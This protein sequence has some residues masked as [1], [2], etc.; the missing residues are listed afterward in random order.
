MPTTISDEHKFLFDLQGYIR[1]EGVLTVAECDEILAVLRRLEDREYE[2]V[3]MESVEGTGRPTR[4]VAKENQVRL[5]GLPRLD[6]IFDDLIGHERVLPY[7]EE[8]VEGPQL[9]NTWSISK[10]KDAA[11]S[12]W[13][14]GV[15]VTDHTHRNGLIRTRMLNTVY[16]LTDNGPED[17]CV[18][19]IPGSHKSNVDL[20]LKTHPAYEMPGATP[21]V[22]K[23]GDLLLFSEATLH[24]GLPK[25]TK[26]IRT[27]L[28]YNY[29]HAHYNGMMREPRNCHHFYF[30]PDVRSRFDET[31][32]RLTNWMEYVKWDY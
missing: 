13:H 1:L 8:F 5:N 3:W 17:G 2:D 4:E 21:V 7:L 14:R 28:Y 19:A 20:D 25:T 26:G 9:I 15:P 11:F 10:W 29:V 27:N 30:P 31:R 18:V 12:G 16:F 24:D 32:Q 23:A 22:G 6:P